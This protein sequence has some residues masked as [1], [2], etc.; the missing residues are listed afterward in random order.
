MALLRLAVV[1]S[2]DHEAVSRLDMNADLAHL[3]QADMMSGRR[4]RMHM[5]LSVS[6]DDRNTYSIIEL[7][8]SV[9]RA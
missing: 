7:E 2:G 8:C 1:K 9:S 6:R 5:K 4:F 3:K